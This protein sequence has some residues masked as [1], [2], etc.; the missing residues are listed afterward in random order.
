MLITITINHQTHIFSHIID[1]ILFSD[2]MALNIG[3]T[4]LIFLTL[5]ALRYILTYY[6]K[7][8]D[9]ALNN[10]IWFIIMFSIGILL[11][12]GSVDLSKINLTP[13]KV[14]IA[15]TD[16]V[17]FSGFYIIIIAII[18]G[19]ICYKVGS[20]ITKVNWDLY[21]SI[22]TYIY[23]VYLCFGI[24]FITDVDKLS[25]FIKIGLAVGYIYII[26]LLVSNHCDI[27]KKSLNCVENQT[28]PNYPLDSF[29]LLYKMRR[30]VFELINVIYTYFKN[31][32]Q[33]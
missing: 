29:N 30:V 26:L 3:T 33:E 9:I 17:S 13:Y 7:P 14:F 23:I 25:L 16:I 21:L 8:T 11:T 5:I 4:I 31:K 19:L 32:F 24:L 27:Y 12:V 22:L 1:K 18:I 2:N 15:L 20:S 28:I 6:V 10:T